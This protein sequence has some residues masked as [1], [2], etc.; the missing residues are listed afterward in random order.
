MVCE[1]LGAGKWG[2]KGQRRLVQ[3][4]TK[5]TVHALADPIANLRVVEAREASGWLECE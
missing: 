2:A 3:Y 4:T 1:W 5:N